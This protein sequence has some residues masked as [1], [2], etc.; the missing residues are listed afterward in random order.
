MKPAA[1]FKPRMAQTRPNMK[2]MTA[3]TPRKFQ[4]RKNRPSGSDRP[5][6]GNSQ[7]AERNY[8]RY[9][10]LARTEALLGDPIAAENY[11]QHAEHYFRSMGKDKILGSSQGPVSRQG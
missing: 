10:A 6:E 9:L 2:A 8:Q 11:L 1:G 3:P 5:Q 7:N 4:P